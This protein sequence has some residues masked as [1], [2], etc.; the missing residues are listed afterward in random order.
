MNDWT[1]LILFVGAVTYLVITRKLTREPVVD[2][3]PGETLDEATTA[4]ETGEV[5]SDDAEPAPEAEVLADA[6]P[7]PLPEDEVVAEP[8][9]ED[10]AAPQPA[11][12]PA[13]T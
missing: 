5:A 11:E 2:H 7:G 3:D 13:P 6:E 4:Y 8:V 1:S 9:P 10:E 12:D